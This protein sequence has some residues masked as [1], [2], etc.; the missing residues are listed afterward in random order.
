MFKALLKLTLC[1]HLASSL[2]GCGSPS[3]RAKVNPHED[4]RSGSI[5]EA[6]KKMS[7][8]NES[9]VNLESLKKQKLQDLA[10]QLTI[11]KVLDG[12]SADLTSCK[13][14]VDLR[15]LPEQ[16]EKICYWLESA[17]ETQ[18]KWMLWQIGQ[19]I[20][21]QSAAICL[22]QS[23]IKNY[24][25]FLKIAPK[26][27]DLKKIYSL[28]NS[29]HQNT[30]QDFTTSLI[31]EVESLQDSHRLIAKTLDFK[32][33]EIN[34]QDL[35][36]LLIALASESGVQSMDHWMAENGTQKAEKQILNL[37]KLKFLLALNKSDT[38]VLDFIKTYE[39]QSYVLSGDTSKFF[40]LV[41][42]VVFK[43][44]KVWNDY[45]FLVNKIPILK[46]QDA[47]TSPISI[48][49]NT[50][51]S[52]I[53]IYSE[54]PHAWVI[55]NKIATWNVTLDVRFQDWTLKEQRTEVKTGR[56]FK[57]IF[58]GKSS[59]LFNYLMTSSREVRPTLVLDSL[60]SLFSTNRFA[61]FKIDEVDFMNIVTNEV[62]QEEYNTQLSDFIR[63]QAT[64]PNDPS[65]LSFENTLS[66]LEK[67]KKLIRKYSMSEF[68]SD[69][70]F[71][72]Y[73][74]LLNERFPLGCST[75]CLTSIKDGNNG[76]DVFSELTIGQF[77]KNKMTFYLDEKLDIA[78]MVALYKLAKKA[79]PD[80]DLSILKKMNMLDLQIGQFLSLQIKRI[81]TLKNKVALFEK[82]FLESFLEYQINQLTKIH[83][84]M[85]ISKNSAAGGD[86][87]AIPLLENSLRASYTHKAINSQFKSKKYFNSNSEFVVSLSDLW[88]QMI[89]FSESYFSQ[90]IDFIKLNDFSKT[91]AYQEIYKVKV[92][93]P[94]MEDQSRFVKA[95]FGA[96]MK[97]PSY[98]NQAAFPWINQVQ[99][100]RITNSMSDTLSLIVMFN[101]TLQSKNN[102]ITIKELTDL[103]LTSLDSLNI[104]D[105]LAKKMQAL[106]LE[107]LEGAVDQKD[108]ANLKHLFI[109]KSYGGAFDYTLDIISLKQEGDPLYNAKF[110]SYFSPD[111]GGPTQ[112]YTYVDVFPHLKDKNNPVTKILKERSIYFYQLLNQTRSEIIKT[113]KKYNLQSLNYQFVVG[114][115]TN[116]KVFSTKYEDLLN[117]EIELFNRS[118]GHFYEDYLADLS[119]R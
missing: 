99:S 92:S 77:L 22:E 15:E 9:I 112:F 93:C 6:N 16:V 19:E 109:D 100:P 118:T 104:S 41:K 119:T 107:S 106:D 45:I 25:E 114:K 101:K 72:N 82:A 51:Q 68:V 47:H 37:L 64:V 43:N 117:N 29:S 66:G 97:I 115:F 5:N 23:F 28:L 31:K 73:Q 32:F 52:L 78:A 24:G 113:L 61:Q 36:Q 62:L 69:P 40:D 48:W 18:K 44:Q 85:S 91:Q 38:I 86:Q 81:S 11:E 84:A 67:N 60:Y 74:Y 76:F 53:T 55:F 50:L 46:L 94:Y 58:K 95:C 71:G 4:A 39:H 103:Y 80:F 108:S 57:S 35:N 10:K 49:K 1:V 33:S 65:W 12:C 26:H 3:E 56:F 54:V 90:Q 59:Q 83:Q 14:L 42:E 30:V 20:K 96:M 79:S 2:V 111:T 87:S 105:S 34:Y 116:L 21:G 8:N 17:I 88:A 89:N 70:F 110:Y 63:L 7:L 102:L 13:N 75:D 98:R 27:I